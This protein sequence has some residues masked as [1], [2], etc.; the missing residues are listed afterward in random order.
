MKVRQ[1][2]LLIVRVEELPEN[3][4]LQNHRVL[5]EGEATGHMHEL[6]SGE[7]YEKSGTLYF[8][9]P[10]DQKTTLTHQEH[11]PITFEPG[12]YKVIRQREYEPRGWRRVAD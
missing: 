8:R 5:A 12:V 11:G 1:G 7:L 2:D 10:E 3:S 6:D 9:V 4:V